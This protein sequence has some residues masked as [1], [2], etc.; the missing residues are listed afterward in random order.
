MA[1]ERWEAIRAAAASLG[2]AEVRAG[3]VGPKANERHHDSDLTNGEVGIIQEMGA[4]SIGLP[5]RSFV[6]KTLRDS[7]FQAE[8]AV[9]QARLVGEVLAGRMNRDEALAAMGAFTAERIR[10]T[11]LDDEVKPE[12]KQS[13]IEAKGSDRVLV[14]HGQLVE[15]IGWEIRK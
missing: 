5:E 10:R 1:A 13:T 12:L 8:F 15:A 7:R 11:I 6:R 9:L 14:D 2:R 3:I 4:P